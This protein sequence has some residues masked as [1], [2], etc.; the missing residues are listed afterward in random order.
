MILIGISTDEETLEDV[1]AKVPEY[2]RKSPEIAHAISGIAKERGNLAETQ[3]WR[4]MALAND[5][6]QSPHFKAALAAVLIEQVL[7]NRTVIL[8]NQ[9][10]ALKKAQLEQAVQLLSEAW[11]CVVNT[12]LRF[13]RSDWV[14]N[15]STVYEILGH[16]EASIKD[17]DTAL[18]LEP[19]N[20]VFIRS[21]ARLLSK[22]G[23]TQ[24]AVPLLKSIQNAK[25]TPEVP[26]MLADVL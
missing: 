20:P 3:K 14:I 24:E 11:E 4:E 19:S 17:V 22:T 9:V 6:G 10:D 8:T 23:K 15:R 26:I 1:I 16:L 7:T 21:K 18:E 12:E 25:E 5:T 2:L 13:A